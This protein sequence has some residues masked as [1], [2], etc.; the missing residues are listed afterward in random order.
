MTNETDW[1]DTED[2]KWFAGNFGV[3]P[4]CKGMDGIVTVEF[5]NR[6]L[7]DYGK[8]DRC[9][10]V[11]LGAAEFISVIEPSTDEVSIVGGAASL[12]VHPDS[13]EAARIVES[14]E[15]VS[16]SDFRTTGQKEAT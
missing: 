4:R 8:C 15:R 13:L 5:T 11:W 2:G 9:R 10:T 7:L 16:G 6:Q 14:Y 12:E 3:C 1:R